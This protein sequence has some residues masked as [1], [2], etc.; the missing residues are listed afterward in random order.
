MTPCQLRIFGLIVLGAALFLSALGSSCAFAQNNRNIFDTKRTSSPPS[1]PRPKADE[2]TK[3]RLNQAFQE[4]FTTGMGDLRS[5][6]Y[7]AVFLIFLGALTGVLVYYD[8]NR[9]RAEMEGFDNPKRLFRELC[10]VHR[11]TAAERKFLR[12][13]AED[14]DLEDPLPLFIEPRYFYDALDRPEHTASRQMIRYLLVKLFDI[15]L[16]K[17]KRTIGNKPFDKHLETTILVPPHAD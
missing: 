3:E 15:K 7:Y 6:L 8:M 5:Y 12:D 10:A 11:L 17:E 4:E 13:F 2:A 16:A 1:R 9:R 14:A